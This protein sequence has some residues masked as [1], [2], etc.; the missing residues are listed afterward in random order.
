MAQ[1]R[2]LIVSPDAAELESRVRNSSLSGIHLAVMSDWGKGVAALAKENFS[3]IVARKFA[4]NRTAEDFVKDILALAPK[5]PLILILP[6]KGGPAVL[7]ALKGGA[8]EILFEESL[9]KELVPTLEKYL[10]TGYGLLRK[11]SLDELFDF[12]FPVIT[13][14][15]MDLLGYT[16]IEM[17]KEALGASFGILFREQEGRGSGFSVVASVGLSEESVA[18]VFLLRFGAGLSRLAGPAPTVLPAEQVAG[19]LPE[20]EEMLGENRTFFAVRFDLSPGSRMFAVLG[21][22]G[23]PGADVLNSTLLNFFYRQAR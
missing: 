16:V 15:D 2:I 5:T 7:G 10:F 13:T 4:R 11:M 8:A 22:R 14:T 18:G 12:S 23:V 19:L 17:F 6:K 21:M 9:A 1:Q 3:I 20:D